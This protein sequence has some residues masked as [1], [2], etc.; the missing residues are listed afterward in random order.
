MLK[1]NEIRK[2]FKILE[3]GKT[4]APVYFDSACMSLKPDQVVEAVDKYYLEYPACAGRS[5]HKLA[6][7]VTQKIKETRSLIAEFIGTKDEKEII[8]TR[9]TTEGINLIA[10]SFP[11]NKGDVVL[12]SD[13]EHNSNLIPW[14]VLRDKIGIEIKII[15]SNEDNTFSLENFKKLVHGARM[16]SIVHT[17]NLDGVTNPA[18]EIIKIAHEAGA[19]VLLDC[20]QSMAHQKINVKD[21]DV[22]FLVFSG[23]KTLGP[24][25][26]G[27]LYGKSELLKKLDSFIVGGDTVF[28]ST[29][30]NYS[31]LE[32]PEKFEAGLGDYAGI[33]GLGE[34]IKFLDRVDFAN[35][36]NHE[37]S[38]NSYLTEKLLEFPQIKII[39]PKDPSLRSSI[40]NFYIPGKDMHQIAVMLDEMSGI[41]VR[42][43]RHCVHSWFNN[44]EI[45][46]SLRISFYLYNT[47]EE[48]EIFINSL[49]KI[50]KII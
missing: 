15:P 28:D 12:L 42:S 19:I 16:V 14:L 6:E 8:F 47:Q 45:L 18:K 46:N 48:A 34:A 33:I 4:K 23:H 25:G 2:N 26:T 24:T 20:A 43:G 35:L 38:L 36:K 31:F 37:L 30:D 7:K 29:Y 39:G 32:V 3:I 41:A 17:S 21:L 9:N 40:V 27:V 5:A 44:K 1:I 13:K 10:K 11:F 22:D 49:S 50:L